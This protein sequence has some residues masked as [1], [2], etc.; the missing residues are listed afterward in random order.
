MDAP[1]FKKLFAIS[2]SKA[3]SSTNSRKYTQKKKSYPQQKRFILQT[4]N[5]NSK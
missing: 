5:Q 2:S 3:L 1:G 4:E